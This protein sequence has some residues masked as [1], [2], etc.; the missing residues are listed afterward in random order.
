MLE[1][2]DLDPLGGV[3]TAMGFMALGSGAAGD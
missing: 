1:R 3:R 2:I